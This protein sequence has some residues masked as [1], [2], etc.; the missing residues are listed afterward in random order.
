MKKNFSRILSVLLTVILVFA[1]APASQVLAGPPLA[2]VQTVH[3][4]HGTTTI[5]EIVSEY[6]EPFMDE[7]IHLKELHYFDSLYLQLN[8]Y[9]GQMDT[10]AVPYVVVDGTPVEI[11]Q[12]DYNIQWYQG[13]TTLYINLNDI[14]QYLNPVNCRSSIG[15]GTEGTVYRTI[16]IE[17][18]MLPPVT[19][20]P[21]IKSSNAASECYEEFTNDYH[22]NLYASSLHYKDNFRFGVQTQ[23]GIAVEV[24]VDGV[25]L[26]E[27]YYT[28][29]DKTVLPDQYPDGCFVQVS[30]K[31]LRKLVGDNPS[32][33]IE[34]HEIG[35]LGSF[36]HTYLHVNWAD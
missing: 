3:S 9:Y 36:N 24:L 8:F 10:E 14:E 15:F 23:F 16:D 18:M 5:R 11:P 26:D 2:Q 32:S 20:A 27:T 29:N 1:C 33:V 13:G 19:S 28:L 31:N 21:Y 7:E 6:G 12:A 4:T 17:W 34:L 35:G 30:L 25:M 22:A